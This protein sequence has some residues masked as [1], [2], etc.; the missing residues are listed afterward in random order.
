MLLI[1]VLLLLLQVE[2]NDK[3]QNNSTINIVATGISTK[4]ASAYSWLYPPLPVSL[5]RSVHTSEQGPPPLASSS[6]SASIIIVISGQHQ[7]SSYLCK[8]DE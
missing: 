5:P 7:Q 1:Y 6:S 4:R 3:G 8:R 2:R